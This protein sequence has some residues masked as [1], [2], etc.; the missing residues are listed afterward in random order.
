MTEFKGSHLTP[1]LTHRAHKAFNIMGPFN[2][3]RDALAG[4]GRMTC[5]AADVVRFTFSHLPAESFSANT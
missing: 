5:W 4:S 3:E 1:E 2:D